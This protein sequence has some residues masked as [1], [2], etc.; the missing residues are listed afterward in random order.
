MRA[1]HSVESMRRLNPGCVSPSPFSGVCGT[2]KMVS[3]WKHQ[4]VRVQIL[5]TPRASLFRK[6]RPSGEKNYK[7]NLVGGFAVGIAGN[8][9]RAM[10]QQKHSTRMRVTAHVMHARVIHGSA[11]KREEP[12]YSSGSP[13]ILVTP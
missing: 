10:L 5:V 9:L 4:H 7:C 8:S 1:A 2:E 6:K 13:E 12:E 3:L 11:F